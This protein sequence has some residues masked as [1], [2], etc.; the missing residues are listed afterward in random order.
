MPVKSRDQ[1]LLNEHLK[2]SKLAV[3][4]ELQLVQSSYLWVILVPVAAKA[5]S[6]VKEYVAPINVFGFTIDV[7]TEL[8]FSWVAFYFAG[9]LFLIAHLIYFFGAPS[10]VKDH[11]SASDFFD[12]GKSHQHLMDYAKA[13]DDPFTQGFR[14]TEAEHRVGEYSAEELRDLFWELFETADLKFPFLRLLCGAL[15]I[16]GLL[17]LAFLIFQNTIFVAR[18]VIFT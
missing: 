8:P 11:R 14:R 5:L 9:I 15:L 7:P 10:I 6:N 17:L 13:L 2:W 1:D 18:T 12:S 3:I 16:V 4:A